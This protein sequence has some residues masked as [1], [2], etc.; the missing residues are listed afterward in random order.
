MVQFSASV[1]AFVIIIACA[2]LSSSFSPNSGSQGHCHRFGSALFASKSGVSFQYS[3]SSLKHLE[4]TELPDDY[5]RPWTPTKVK[6]LATG[7]ATGAV[8]GVAG[9]L[10]FKSFMDSEKTF[11]VWASIGIGVGWFLGGGKQVAEEER[12]INGGYDR[13]LIADRP[14]RLNSVLESLMEGNNQVGV[15]STVRDLSNAK[16]YASKVH[17]GEYISLLESKSK[18]A[19]RPGRLNPVYA[20]TLI[21][22]HSFGAALNAVAD[23]MESVDAAIQERPKFALVRPPSH[24]ACKAKGMG[25]CLLNSVSIAAVYALDQPKVESVAILD[26]DAHHGNGI[27]HCIQDIPEIRYCS[28]H[29]DASSAFLGRARED[30]DDPRSATSDDCG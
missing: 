7:F 9:E 1:R 5:S 12:P 10:L 3:V 29:E 24:H 13:K 8:L 28:I 15:A 26:I 23:W 25:G 17:N 27:A 11:V 16:L 21:D 14:S 19:D 2:Q 18:E 4:N 20:R 30:T 22:Q 6:A